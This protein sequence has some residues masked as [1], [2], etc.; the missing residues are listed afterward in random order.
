MAAVPGRSVVVTGLEIH[1]FAD[2]LDGFHPKVA[3]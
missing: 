3:I 1:D 2:E